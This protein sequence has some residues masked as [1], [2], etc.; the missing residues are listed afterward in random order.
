[1]IWKVIG[2]LVV[3]LVAILV[4]GDVTARVYAQNQLQDRINANVPNA[5]AK[6]HISGFPFLGKLLFTGKVDKI[7]A[8]I[9]RATEGQ[10]TFDGIDLTVNGVK[11]NRGQLIRNRRVKVQSISSGTVKAD[12][13]QEDF[14]RL[15]GGLP[16]VLGDGTVQLTAGG[17]TVTAQV[18]VVDNQLHFS[19]R[20][21]PAVI[22]IPKLPVLPCAASITIIPGHLV[23]TC[24]FH[25]VPT[26]LLQAAGQAA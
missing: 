14:D 12:M 13:S 6:A 20:G 18:T 26:A 15:V 16:V 23:V 4:V 1:L 19:G 7:T 2:A 21:L 25:E 24:T 9:E 10:F 3:L 17:T 22:P 11:L 5:N 8:H